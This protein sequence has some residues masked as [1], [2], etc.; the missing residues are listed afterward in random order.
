MAKV[1]YVSHKYGGHWINKIK[2]QRKIIKLQKEYPEYV[3]LSPVHATGF[4][5][6]KMSY[7]DGI[8]LCLELLNRSDELWI[9]SEH[10]KGTLIETKHALERGIKVR[11]KR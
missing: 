2:V 1:I 9:L 3:F 5:Y 11:Y 10:S 7:D 8:K 6:N 4:L